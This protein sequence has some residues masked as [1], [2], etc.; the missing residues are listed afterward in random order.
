MGAFMNYETIDA[1]QQ[2]LIGGCLKRGG[3]PCPSETGGG[4]RLGG[5]DVLSIDMRY[6]SRFAVIRV[7]A[8][9]L[10]VYAGSC[11][12]HR[13]HGDL[14]QLLHFHAIGDESAPV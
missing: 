7:V 6:R 10:D 9:L 12:P 5:C 3:R 1:V 8:E 2:L 13:A 11:D 4:Q 14:I